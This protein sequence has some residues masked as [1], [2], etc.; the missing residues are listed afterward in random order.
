MIKISTKRIDIECVSKIGCLTGTH[1]KLAS[2]E[3][4]I[5]DVSSRLKILSGII[6]VKK[7]CVKKREKVKSIASACNREESS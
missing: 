1:V 4:Y 2:A 7:E 5:K 3:Y 6:D